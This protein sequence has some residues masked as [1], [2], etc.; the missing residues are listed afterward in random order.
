MRYTVAAALAAFSMACH[1]GSVH[2]GFEVRYLTGELDLEAEARGFFGTFRIEDEEDADLAGIEIIKDFTYDQAEESG[3]AGRL[4]YERL[5]V[6]GDADLFEAYLSGHFSLSPIR[7]V[8]TSLYISGGLTHSDFEDIDDDTGY[9][10]EIGIRWVNEGDGIPLSI[11]AGG[12]YQDL[13]EFDGF[14]VE[15][16]RL[17]IAALFEVVDNLWIGPEVRYED[18][19]FDTDGANIDIDGTIYGL[20][21]RGNPGR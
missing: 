6:D 2:E 19:S 15:R 18:I 17:W 12:S 1:A 16:G 10:G 20:V 21:L 8:V 14:D 5:D 13:G 9:G 3:I 11:D 4:S 7:D